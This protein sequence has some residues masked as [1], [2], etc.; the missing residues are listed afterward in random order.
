[1]SPHRIV[2]IVVF[3]FHKVLEELNEFLQ[4]TP[5][6]KLVSHPQCSHKHQC[7]TPEEHGVV[8]CELQ[9]LTN[10]SGSISRCAPVICILFGCKNDMVSALMCAVP[11]VGKYVSSSF[12]RRFN[13]YFVIIQ[14]P[15]GHH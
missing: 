8:I 3:Q 5:D 14:N 10:L 13:R 11:V 4:Y 1:M 9:S 12:L 6:T 2:L 7:V 15:K